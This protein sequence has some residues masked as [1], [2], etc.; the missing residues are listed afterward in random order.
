[1][2]F[3]FGL[4]FRFGL[5][6]AL[7]IGP[8]WFNLRNIAFTTISINVLLAVFNMIPLSPLDGSSILA[9]ILP[10]PY[11]YRLAEFNARF[12]Q[13]LI[14]F[15]MADMLLVAPLL[16]RSILGLILSPP[17]RRGDESDRLGHDMSQFPLDGPVPDLPLSEH[18]HGYSRV[19]FAKARRESS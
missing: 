11:G 12:P 3:L 15:L 1:M 7:D 13:A 10:D 14:L 16:G 9:G 17:R 5:D 6:P 2:A 18:V 4:I 8:Q 19:L